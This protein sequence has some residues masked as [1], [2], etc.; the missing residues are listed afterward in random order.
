MD[1][2]ALKSEHGVAVLT[3][4]RVAEGAEPVAQAYAGHQF[5]H[6]VPQLGD[7]V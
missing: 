5:G 3:G 2:E 1:S 4:T 7:G 6:F